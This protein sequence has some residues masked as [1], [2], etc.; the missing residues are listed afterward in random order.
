MNYKSY[1][2]EQDIR[3]LKDKINLFYGENIGLKNDFKKSIKKNNSNF[4]IINFNQEE[5]IAN[6]NLFY[7]EF[8]NNSLFEENKILYLSRY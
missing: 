6:Q 7:N 2:I 1:L 4:I 5:I 3:I 8:Y